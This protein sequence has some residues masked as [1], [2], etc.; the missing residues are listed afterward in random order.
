[1]MSLGRSAHIFE[2]SSLLSKH[3]FATLKDSDLTTKPTLFLSL[4]F[5]DYGHH[6]KYYNLIFVEYLKYLGEDGWLDGVGLS[7]FVPKQGSAQCTEFGLIQE[8]VPGKE[9]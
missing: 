9:K 5:L 7:T 6:P 8:T 2:L 4:C 3:Q 1:M